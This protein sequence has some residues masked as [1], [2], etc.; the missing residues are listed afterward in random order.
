MTFL[1]DINGLK[2]YSVYVGSVYWLWCVMVG[3]LQATE[4][5][6]KA[7]EATQAAGVK[8]QSESCWWWRVGAQHVR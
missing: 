8:T 4:W 2:L 6:T 7:Q 1:L 5:C 3:G